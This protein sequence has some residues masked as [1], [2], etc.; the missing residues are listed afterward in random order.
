VILASLAAAVVVAAGAPAPA[1]AP[2]P[3]APPAPAPP[4]EAPDAAA[5]PADDDAAM[6]QFETTVRA[7]P[8]APEPTRRTLDAEEVGRVAGT[9]GDTLKAVLNLPGAARVPFGFGQLI[10]RGSSPGDSQTFLDGQP[11]PA[12]FHFGGLRST[13]NARFLEAIDF[14]PGNFA[15]DWG[16][17]TG[18]V[19]NVRVR[20]PAR[21]AFHGEAG[22]SFYDAGLALEGPLSSTWSVGGAFRRSYVDA[23]LPAVLPSD[24]DL[25]FDTAPRYYDYQFVASRD[26]GG[27]ER[28]RFLFFGSLDELAVLLE[29]PADDPAIRGTIEGR[30]MFHALQGEWARPVGP[31]RQE[32]TLQLALQEIDTSFG[33]QFFFR[34]TNRQL[35]G[36][37][38]WSWAAAPRVE[39]RGGLD[40]RFSSV[41]VA[42]NVPDAP[43]EGEPPS[44]ISTRPEVGTSKTIELF[45][46]GAFAELRLGPSRGVTLTPGVRVDWYGII[47]RWTVDPRLNARWELADGTALKA[48]VGV[49]SQPPDPADSDPDVGTPELGPERSLH[50]SAGVE[51]RLVDGLD[52]DATLFWKRLTR[53]VVRNPAFAANPSSDRY[54][55]E[56]LG[57]IYG[58]ELLVRGRRGR[59]AGWVAYT[60][61]RSLR[62]DGF[63][64][65]ERSFD[66]DQPHLLTAVAQWDPNRRWGFSARFRLTSGNPF[67]PVV[68][69]VYDS[70]GDVFVPLFGTV[71]DDRLGTF[72]ALDV[73]VDRTW[74][75]DRWRLVAFLDV[76]NVTNRANQE[77][78]EYRFDYRERAPLTG[79]PILPILGVKGEW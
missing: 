67:T 55:N 68:G 50:V 75:F 61:Q 47:G 2:A 74:R 73:R 49:Y 66:Y 13:F 9:Q 72:A 39:A 11:I 21:D 60:L 32:T 12:L 1:D 43:R 70:V 69:S 4:G 76:Q 17:A 44:P 18:G 71:N 63:G 77:G 3:A 20:D 23:I 25:S 64:S 22:A 19:V 52:A 33:P 54:V 62:E 24:A 37:S 7:A 58:L 15:V 65:P 79:L 28:L 38:A 57:R 56:G 59:L 29:R 53:L 40:V 16:R 31:L 51:R 6:P 30:V 27:G 41:D 8:V 45:T 5:P 36:R 46:P 42:L 34:L 78:W 48:G 35:S 26:P 14:V 10:L